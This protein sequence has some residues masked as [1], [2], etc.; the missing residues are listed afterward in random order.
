MNITFMID[1]GF[2]MNLNLKTSYSDFKNYYYGKDPQDKLS[3]LL[4]NEK[5]DYWS[6]LEV[7]LGKVLRQYSE[8]EIDDFL[9]S[10][11]FMEQCFQEYLSREYARFHINNPEELFKSFSNNVTNFYSEF[12]STEKHQYEEFLSTTSEK[13]H[14]AFI[15]YNYTYVLDDIIK[16]CSGTKEFGQHKSRTYSSTCCYVVDAPLHIHGDLESGIVFGVDNSN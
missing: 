5:C 6:D 3:A 15:S 13:L 14:Y 12:N 1:N 10:K 7:S 4:K 9:D 16:N 8:S 11:D 2:D